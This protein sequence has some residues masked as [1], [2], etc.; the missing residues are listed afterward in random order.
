MLTFKLVGFTE[1][2]CMMVTVAQFLCKLTMELKECFIK[3]N[4]L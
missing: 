2:M 1:Q 4:A 3:S